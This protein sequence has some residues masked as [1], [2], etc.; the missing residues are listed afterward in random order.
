MAKEKKDIGN[1]FLDAVERVGNKLPDPVVLFMILGALILLASLIVSLFNVS[2]TNPA[3]DETVE[4]V[5]L[6]SS[7]GI[8]RILTESITNFTE[9]PA[10]GMVLVVMIGIGIGEKSG[11]FEVLMKRTLEVSPSKLILPVLI[12]VGI[13]S[14]VAGDAGPVI[15][16]PIA[17]MITL[18]LGY[19]PF[20][21]LFMAYAA[22]NGAFSA[23]FIPGMTDA[24]AAGF[25]ESGA[26][27]VDENYSA[28][29]VMNYYFIAASS[30]LLLIAI[31]FISTKVTAPRLGEYKGEQYDTEKIT[32][33][34]KIA[35]RW[36]NIGL[37]I[38]L[39]IYAALSIPSNGILRN[40]DTG[41][42]VDEA[43]LMDSAV[44]LITILFFVPGLIYGLK[45]KTIKDTKDFG[46]M[47][48]DS[49]GT[50]GSYIVLVFFAAQMLAFFEWSNLGPIIAIYGSSLLESV[51]LTGIPLFI[52]FIFIVGLIN[53]LI[54]SA[55]A[56][57]AIMAP[58]FIPMFMLLDYDPAFTQMLY[59][60]GDS[61]TN[62]ISPMLP[63]L[64]LLLTFAKKYDKDVKL[65]TLIA[66]LLPYS[67]ILFIVWTI[68]LII[69]YLI[70]LPVGPGGPIY[71]PES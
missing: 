44:V 24:L 38:T 42:L 37:V 56:K 34:Q 30:I 25:T 17:A 32:Q 39:L 62:P 26:R 14:N 71:L 41:S 1:R 59:R 53:I 50:M 13:I 61:I 48:G 57:W 51:N 18:K 22:T 33:D 43:P 6:L 27:L 28:N 9:F 69:W 49:M 60:I 20:L 2:V 8:I 63:F 54:G 64:P 36:A 70:G 3:T 4:A 12:L 7:D 31:Y 21:G 68:F 45:A 55:S 11:Y 58:V 15:L 29:I 65:G 5:N 19:H 10:L 23:N 46:E 52:G 67:I 16:P 35:L 66:N 40:P 47:L